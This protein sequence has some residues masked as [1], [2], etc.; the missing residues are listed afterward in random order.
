MDWS[1]RIPRTWSQW[2]R[3]GLSGF[4][5]HLKPTY[6]FSVNNTPSGAVIFKLPL[7]CHI[8]LVVTIRINSQEKINYTACNKSK[9]LHVIFCIKYECIM[10]RDFSDCEWVTKFE[11][12]LLAKRWL[13]CWYCSLP[14]TYKFFLILQ[15]LSS[16]K[17]NNFHP[18]HIGKNVKVYQVLMRTLEAGSHS[19]IMEKLLVFLFEAF[20]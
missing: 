2:V 19:M 18:H 12:F 20:F 13:S 5:L 9:L 17:D 10:T 3:H 4:H 11:V 14:V 1:Q 8:N 7:G 15:Y 6:L 16:L